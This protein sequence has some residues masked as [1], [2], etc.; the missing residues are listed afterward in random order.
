MGLEGVEAG[1]VNNH[2]KEACYVKNRQYKRE[3]VIFEA[4]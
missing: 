1:S 4:T 3:N 2:F